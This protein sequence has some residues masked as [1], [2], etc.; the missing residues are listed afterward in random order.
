MQNHSRRVTAL[1]PDSR[2]PFALR[3]ALIVSQVALNVK[4]AVL[5]SGAIDQK[6]PENCE[7]KPLH[8]RET[9]GRRL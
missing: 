1:M 5:R 4:K 6:N 8:A 2:L 9:L 3:L 7:Q